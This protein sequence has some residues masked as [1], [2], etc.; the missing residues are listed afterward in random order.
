MQGN[1]ALWLVGVTLIG[2]VEL[3]LLADLG[4]KFPCILKTFFGMSLFSVRSGHIAARSFMMTHSFLNCPSGGF[5]SFAQ[6][7]RDDAKTLDLT[8]FG[9]TLSVQHMKLRFFLSGDGGGRTRLGAGKY[10]SLA[11]WRMLAQL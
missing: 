9:G 7:R 6:E 10:G 1:T 3:W 4:G 11:S 2:A 5:Q 8:F